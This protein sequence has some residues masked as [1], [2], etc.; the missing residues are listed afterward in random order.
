MKLFLNIIIIFLLTTFNINSYAETLKS[1]ASE[2]EKIRDEISNLDQSSTLEAI[3]I[4]QSLKEL[5]KVLDFAEKQ[6]NENDIETAVSSLNIAEKTINGISKIIPE[7]FTTEIDTKGNDFSDP[8]MKSILKISNN[9]KKTKIQKNLKLAEDIIDIKSKGLDIMEITENINKMGIKIIDKK[10]ISKSIA[11]ASLSG[12]SN[13]SSRGLKLE[14]S[15]KNAGFTD[16][17]IRDSLY[18]MGEVD[19]PTLR[20]NWAD[21]L[22]P[23]GHRFYTSLESAGFSDTKIRDVIYGVGEVD[24]PTL[25]NN[26]ADELTPRG[27]RFYSTLESAGFSENDI[28][29]SLYGVGEV[30]KPTLTGTWKDE[31]SS[32]GHKI[33]KSLEAAGISEN[34]IKDNLYGAGEI[35]TPTLTGTWKDELSARGYRIA[36]TMQSSGFSDSQIRDSVYA[37]G[38]IETPTLTGTWK[39]DL[40]SRGH[41]IYTSMDAAGFSEKEIKSSLYGLGE[42]DSYKLEEVS[43]DIASS[44]SETAKQ[45]AKEVAETVSDTVQES[46]KEVAKEVAQEISKEVAETVKEAAKEAT[47]GLADK[48]TPRGYRIYSSMKSAGFT[49]GEI[50]TTIDRLNN[51]S[52]ESHNGQFKK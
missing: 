31:L 39:D 12:N 33:A 42:V 50:E 37:A 47:S 5:N 41:G 48:L 17:Q 32:R 18:G 24:K 26:W 46:A 7:I 9:I 3:K 52:S 25:R 23:R 20:G 27:H 4:D 49:D 14:N 35:E 38:E 16:E 40:S 21:E 36:K 44:V 11:I 43:Q 51:H 15:F 22:S 30:D 45:S 2:I 13:L 29:D 34:D 1:L 10:E 8:E 28:R 19:K 6:V